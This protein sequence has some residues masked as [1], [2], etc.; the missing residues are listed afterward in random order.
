MRRQAHV[1]VM[2]S[3]VSRVIALGRTMPWRIMDATLGEGGYTRHFLSQVS[4][5]FWFS[6]VCECVLTVLI[7]WTRRTQSAKWWV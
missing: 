2:L 5:V 6:F 7:G 3:E 4:F 1:P